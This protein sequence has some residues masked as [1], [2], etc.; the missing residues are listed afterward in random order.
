M[1][2]HHELEQQPE[3]QRGAEREHQRRQEAAGDRVER[4]R[5]IGAQHVLN[6]VCQVDEVHD[7][8]HQRQA[9]R[10]Q[11]QQHAEL[12]PVEDLDNEKRGGHSGT[13]TRSPHEA[14]RN[15]G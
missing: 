10:D 1:P 12:Q 13:E 8:E 6:A 11:E 15:A 5:E 7:P 9:G 4:D 14:K 2:E 3:Q